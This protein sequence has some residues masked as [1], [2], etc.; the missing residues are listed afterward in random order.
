MW[1]K[2]TIIAVGI[3]G[4]VLGLCAIVA[5]LPPTGQPEGRAAVR[6]D[7]NGV[8]A[9]EARW[10]LG[11]ERAVTTQAPDWVVEAEAVA[12]E[13]VA[14][15]PVAKVARVSD[16]EDEPEAVRPLKLHRLAWALLWLADHQQPDG[17]WTLH[18]A[19]QPGRR[20]GPVAYV[21]PGMRGIPAELSDVGRTALAIQAFLNMGYDHQ[22]EYRNRPFA[23]RFREAVERGIAWL[24][25][26]QRKTGWIGNPNRPGSTINHALAAYAISDAYDMTGD[27]A[28]LRSA[29][30]AVARLAAE[31]LRDDADRTGWSTR[32]GGTNVD[33]DTTA[34]VILALRAARSTTVSNTDVHPIIT[35]VAES[36]DPTAMAAG[37]DRSP[38]QLVQGAFV[39]F[40]TSLDCHFDDAERRLGERAAD[41][42]PDGSFPDEGR[43]LSWDWF[44]LSVASDIWHNESPRRYWGWIQTLYNA[45]WSQQRLMRTPPA[46]PFSAELPAGI[47]SWDSPDRVAATALAVMTLSNTYCYCRLPKGFVLVCPPPHYE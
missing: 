4:T 33:A 37:T 20:S 9:P 30:P 10:S 39:R 45:V 31:R 47:G 21:T 38:L 36:L 17:R 7:V 46:D 27:P 41:P 13:P 34:W 19:P 18:G 25:A 26:Q 28:V 1:I 32:P 29:E 44:A 23:E 11:V 22:S 12:G 3:A 24:I 14:G 15:E 2:A 5:G 6:N 43:D 40:A 16:A 8:P 42:D 35:A